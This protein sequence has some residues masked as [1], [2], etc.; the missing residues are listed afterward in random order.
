MTLPAGS[1]NRAVISG[2]S[3]PIGWTISPPFATTAFTVAATL[4]T[5]RKPH[6]RTPT[7][8]GRL[9]RESRGSRSYHCEQSV[10]WAGNS[11]ARWR[12]EA[13]GV[14]LLGQQALREVEALFHF[15]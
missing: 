11:L 7:T 2:A 12:S 4:S 15:R 9:W 10:A 13:L 3:A 1:R 5:I 6:D 14:A 8:V